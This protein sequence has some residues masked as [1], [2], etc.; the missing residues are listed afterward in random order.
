MLAWLWGVIDPWG[1]GP[2]PLFALHL[3]LFAAGTGLLAEGL[4]RGGRPLAALL[5]LA[6]ALLPIPLGYVGVLMKDTTL[7][8]A[9]LAAFGL[10]GR[11]LLAGRRVPLW[12]ALVA[13]LLALFAAL[14][15]FN[16]PF[17]VVPAALC[18]WPCL[19][20]RSWR[21]QGL[22]GL[23]ALAAALALAP[24]ASQA[25]FRPERTHVALSPI[26]YALGG[27]TA[28]SGRDQFPDL[29]EPDFVARNA[30]QC[31][32]PSGGTTTA[33]ATAA[34]S[35]NGCARWP[36]RGASAPCASGSPR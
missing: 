31:T 32:R 21:V 17:A 9:L 10:V 2:W 3:L 14:L 33:S 20:A 22:V 6:A 35:S 1:L 26:I 7:A 34:S 19:R 24:L 5:V 8:L 16:A 13:A 25:V 28:R 4:L 29:G 15:R 27:I 12:A 18:L 23:A 30:R 11:F 36:R